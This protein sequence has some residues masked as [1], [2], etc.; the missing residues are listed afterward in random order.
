LQEEPPDAMLAH[1]HGQLR[2]C[3]VSHIVLRGHTVIGHIHPC[4][5][6]RQISL[7]AVLHH[8]VQVAALHKAVDVG[9][10]VAVSEFLHDFTLPS[11]FLQLL[12]VTE[13]YLFHYISIVILLRFHSVDHAEPSLAYLTLDYVVILASGWVKLSLT[14]ASITSLELS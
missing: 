13:S 7:L 2:M 5:V 8:Q 9:R 4:Q 14:P 1:L 12:H 6:V 11:S 10:N 3:E